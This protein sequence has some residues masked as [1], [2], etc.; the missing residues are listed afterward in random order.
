MTS[1]AL[2]LNIS[3]RIVG[4]EA[5]R[6]QGVIPAAMPKGPA[7][8]PPAAAPA[9]V[10]TAVAALFLAKRSSKYCDLDDEWPSDLLSKACIVYRYMK[11]TCLT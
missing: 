4:S 3:D 2:T 7:T 1:A 5:G 8:A 11:G 9:T 10:A 6:Y